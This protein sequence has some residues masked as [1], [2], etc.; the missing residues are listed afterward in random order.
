M[1]AHVPT[2]VLRKRNS[3]LHCTLLL[4]NKYMINQRIL[5]SCKA[6]DIQDE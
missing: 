4:K 6:L 2:N 5:M 1:R 3:K